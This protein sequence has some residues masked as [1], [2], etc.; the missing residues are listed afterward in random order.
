MKK[1][2]I[3]K[4]MI[5]IL[6][7]IIIIWVING[8]RNFI[9][10]SK[11][12][13]IL[14]DKLEAT[15]VYSKIE[16][17]EDNAIV[18]LYR[19]ENNFKY[20]VDNGIQRITTYKI[21][22]VVTSFIDTNLEDGTEK[23]MNVV[24]DDQNELNYTTMMD[25]VNTNTLF[26]K[27]VNS[28]FSLIK[29]EKM[30]DKDCY[31]IINNGN[32]TNFMYSGDVEKMKV[33][34]DKETGLPVTAIEEYNSGKNERVTNY[35]YQFGVVTDSDLELP[36]TSEY[37][38]V[39]AEWQEYPDDMDEEIFLWL[40]GD[41]TVVENYKNETMYQLMK[42]T[43]YSFSQTYSSP[44]ECPFI[45]LYTSILGI[46]DS[47]E[48]VDWTSNY[49]AYCYPNNVNN[50]LNTNYNKV[51]SYDI[52]LFNEQYKDGYYSLEQQTESQYE[53][54]GKSEEYYFN[55]SKIAIMNGNNESEGT[56]MNFDRAKK[57]KITANDEEEYIFELNDTNEVQIFDINYKQNSIQT[58]V[59]LKIE[60]LDTYEG[61][62]DS[63]VYISD[64]QF[65]IE[66]NIPQGR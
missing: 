33:Y 54:L 2:K 61:E 41:K 21:N 47:T 17:T 66:S 5:L 63:D 52:A 24:E 26:E 44:D 40:F 60:V 65:A 6:L 59:N 55:K 64:V 53:Q 12:E 22:N 18:E 50:D 3:L 58:P 30:N 38:N 4:T 51:I 7:I 27:I 23:T 57:I 9:I 62:K 25:Y 15:N 16:L 37:N 32:Y 14:Q 20:I 35:E 42:K 39:F 28:L 56:Y 48:I 46:G 8:I 43:L 49:A 11:L 29:T 13:K 45:N 34:L 10:I 19:K 1:K 31:V 36:D